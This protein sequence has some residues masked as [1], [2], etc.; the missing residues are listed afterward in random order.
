M[1]MRSTADGAHALSELLQ[2][3][4][5]A[6]KALNLQRNNIGV[7]GAISIAQ[8]L[9][10]NYSLTSLNLDGHLF[11]SHILICVHTLLFS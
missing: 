2:H 7:A 3:E 1:S 5:C 8:S 9:S 6:I 4:K 10:H 11:L